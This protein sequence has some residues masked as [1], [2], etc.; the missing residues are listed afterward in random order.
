MNTTHAGHPVNHHRWCVDDLCNH[1][2]LALQAIFAGTDPLD[3]FAPK[4]R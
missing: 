3:I 2:A 4:E 1:Q